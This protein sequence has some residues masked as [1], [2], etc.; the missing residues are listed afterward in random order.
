MFFFDPL[1][2]VGYDYEAFAGASFRSLVLPNIGDN[3]YDLYLPQG[4]QYVLYRVV[5]GQ[6]ELFLPD[7][8]TK[9]RISGIEPE[10]GLDPNDQLAFVTGLS[11]NNQTPDARFLMSPLTQ[12]IPDSNTVPEPSCL[13]LFGAGLAGLLSV[14]SKT[15]G[16]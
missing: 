8:T 3:F 12:N 16:K 7:G 15:S 5:P 10:A 9:F 2:A 11:F 4:D 13:L 6:T 14:K 1:V